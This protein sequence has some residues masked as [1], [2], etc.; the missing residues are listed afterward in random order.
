MK[1]WKIDPVHSEIKFKVKHLVVSTVTGKF[2]SFDAAIESES[3]DFTNAKITF[4]ADVN[5]INT[6][7][8]MRDGHLKSADFFDAANHP[9]IMFVSK[10]LTEKSDN[11]YTL[12][13]DITIRGITKQILLDVV[14]NGVAKGMDGNTIAGF[15]I[16]GKLNRFEFGLHWNTL[17]EAGGMTVGSDIKLEIFAEMKNIIPLGKA[18]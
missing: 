8:G 3:D 16:T 17:T 1:T 9:K 15:E 7:N 13:G 6:G 4:E 18:A 5:S 14:Y 10:S 11:E 2:D 12:S